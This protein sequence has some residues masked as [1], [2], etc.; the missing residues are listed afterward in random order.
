MRAYHQTYG[1]DTTISNCSNN[2]GPYQFPEKLIPLFVLNAMEG[3]R[4]PVYGDGR[5]IRDWLYVEDHCEAIL[6][7]IKDGRVGETYHVGGDNQP[8]NLSVVHTLC[9]ILDEV[10]PDSEYVPHKSLIQFVD[11]RPGHDRRYAMDINKIRSELG[12]QPRQSLESGLLRTIQWYLANPEWVAAVR[13]HSDYD[14]WVAANYS[15]RGEIA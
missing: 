15:K 14:Q 10:M 11:D 4:L 1:L 5:Q 12:W 9:D 7:V 3:R 6:T 13:K 2:Y 8:T